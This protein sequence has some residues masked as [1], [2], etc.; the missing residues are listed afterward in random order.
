MEY[1]N[2]LNLPQYI[3]DWLEHD[4]YDHNDDPYT[5]STTT[6]MKPTRAYLLTIRHKDKLQADVSDMVS[7]R[8]GS[9]IHDSIEVIETP[10]VEKENRL[11]REVEMGAVTYT[12]TGK[13][14]ILDCHDDGTF[15]LRDIKTTSVWSY[16]LGGKDE[17][18]CKQLSIYRWLLA[19]NG[20]EAR[21]KGYID[22]FFTDWQRSKAKQDPKYPQ[23]KVLPGYEIDLWSLEETEEYVRARLQLVEDNRNL[24]DDQLLP[25]T[26]TE[27]WADDEKYAVMK[28]RAKRATKLCSSYAEAEE[29]IQI[30]GLKA[31]VERRPPKVKRC[32]YCPAFPFCN[33]GQSYKNQGLLA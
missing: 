7:S 10:G 30:K 12:V 8:I 5:V 9:A 33:Q 32:N 2:N 25:C 29:Y 15:T 4:N 13:Y 18:Y 11:S 31:F 16:V 3:V 17:D 14:D 24:A 6:L 22:F 28:P 26:K 27:V 19:G 21:D 23:N 1:T 20:K